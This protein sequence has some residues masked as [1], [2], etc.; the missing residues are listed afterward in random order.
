[1]TRNKKCPP[2]KREVHLR[3]EPFG[4]LQHQC[5]TPLGT[6]PCW[7]SVDQAAPSTGTVSPTAL[8]ATSSVTSITDAAKVGEL[9][10]YTVGNVSL[11]R[12]RSAMIPFINDPVEVG[13]TLDLQPERPRHP[14]AQRRTSEEHHH[15]CQTPPGWTRDR[16]R[17]RPLRGRRADSTTC[18]PAR[19]G[20][21]VTASICRSQPT[22]KNSTSRNSRPSRVGPRS[23]RAP[24]IVTVKYV[25]AREYSFENKA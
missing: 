12:Q 5:G 9:F 8:D 22:S 2:R 24:S 1:M 4:N 21:L 17:R 25:S 11:P 19:P 23:S 16:L 6:R 13:K 15:G 10:Q 18:H 3:W 7:S 20:C 14:P